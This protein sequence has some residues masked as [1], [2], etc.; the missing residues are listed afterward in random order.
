MRVDAGP[1]A[2]YCPGGAKWRGVANK[3]M[4]N[5]GIMSGMMGLNEVS[6]M[7]VGIELTNIHQILL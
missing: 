3:E 4:A 2:S 5:G 1:R 7:S 6:S